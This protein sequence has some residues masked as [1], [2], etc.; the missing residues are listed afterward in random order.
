MILRVWAMYNQSKVILSALL[1]LFSLQ[2]IF[3][4]LAAAIYSDPRND[5]G[6]HTG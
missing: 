1:P 4:I 2:I 6:M 5:S 3:T